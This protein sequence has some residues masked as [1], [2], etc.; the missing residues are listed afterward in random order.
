M[1]TTT[2]TGEKQNSAESARKCRSHLNQELFS[3]NFNCDPLN[4]FLSQ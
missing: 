2:K 4:V 3:Q 1:K